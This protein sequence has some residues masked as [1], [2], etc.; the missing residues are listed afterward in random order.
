MHLEGN[1]LYTKLNFQS[2]LFYAVIP[3]N[4]SLIGKNAHKVCGYLIKHKN[5]HNSVWGHLIIKKDHYTYLTLKVS[6]NK[7]VLFFLLEALRPR[8]S[9]FVISQYFI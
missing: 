3:K 6:G 4:G 7:V 8:Y 5:V 9:C 1:F 2:L